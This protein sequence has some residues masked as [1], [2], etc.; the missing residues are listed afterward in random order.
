[1]ASVVV[2]TS[3]LLFVPLGRGLPLARLPLTAELV[4]A[5]GSTAGIAA[6]AVVGVVPTWRLHLRLR[7]ALRFPPGVARRTG[8]LALVGVVELVMIDL[9][10]VVAIALANG[11]GSTGAIVIF[12]YASQV[13]N[14]VSAVLALSVVVSAFPVLAARDG[15]AFSRTCAGSTRAVLLLS[16]LGTAVMAAVA[17]PAAHVLAHTGDQVPQLIE[18]FA[19]FAPGIA[20]AAVITNLARVMFAVGRLKVA[21]AGV[22]G[23]WLL[24]MTAEAALAFLAPAQLVVAAL[25][26]GTTIGQ[27]AVAIPMVIATRRICGRDSVAGVVRAN[28][29]GLAAGAAGAAIGVGVCLAM[30]VAGKLM[31]FGVAVL[32]ACGAVAAFGAVAYALDRSDLKVVATQLRRVLGKPARPS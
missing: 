21:A 5:A 31:A 18:A 6:L 22:A 15:P 25:A 7:P 3:C 11:R 1:M 27:T 14:S 26:L 10:S 2:I 29:S 19:L 24:V 23:S 12:N 28:L 9:A 4:L 30:P 13:F 8:G 16:W 20:G 32:A 17:V